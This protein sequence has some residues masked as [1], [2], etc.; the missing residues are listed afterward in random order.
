ME[1]NSTRTKLILPEYGRHMQNMVDYVVTIEDRDKRSTAAR[2]LISAMAQLAP[3]QKDFA[4]YKRKLWDH[5]HVMSDF[6]LDV[7][8]PYP[9]PTR[10][11]LQY[12]PQPVAY[13]YNRIRY[14]HHGKII[15]DFITKAS[16]MEEGTA[17]ENVAVL[18][19]NLLKKSYLTWNRDSVQDEI[20]EKQLIELSDGKLSLG[21]NK[22]SNTNE[23]LGPPKIWNPGPSNRRKPNNYQQNRRKKH[24]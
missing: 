18:L 17:K 10:E 6:K 16:E 12:K 24:K 11:D 21:D 14:R 3:A 9:A 22:L 8:S 1:Y 5:L 19:A 4:D 20:I 13:Y 15:Q 7:D 2:Y 23:L